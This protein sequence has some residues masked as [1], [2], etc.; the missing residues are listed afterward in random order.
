MLSKLLN[1]VR[2]V[3]VTDD[4]EDLLLLVC[5]VSDVKRTVSLHTLMTQLVDYLWGFPLIVNVN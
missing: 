3:V 5:D 4:L 2:A 1:L